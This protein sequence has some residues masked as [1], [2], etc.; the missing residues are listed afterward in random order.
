MKQFISFKQFRIGLLMGLVIGILITVTSTAFAN[1]PIKLLINGQYINCDVQPQVIDG[2]IMVPARFIAEN[3][4]ANVSWDDT[5]KTVIVNGAGY[6]AP[7]V[8]NI[9]PTVNNTEKQEFLALKTKADSFI[10]NSYNIVMED[11]NN[12]SIYDSSLSIKM[13]IMRWGNITSDYS[14]AKLYYENVLADIGVLNVDNEFL[15]QFP[16]NDKYTSERA[17]DKGELLRDKAKLDAELSRLQ[18]LGKL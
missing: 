9:K 15:A 16:G 7:I 2:R 10:A 5:N 18:K 13:E 4:G 3:L 8:S 14:M 11:G 12:Q 17:K 6:V 1:A